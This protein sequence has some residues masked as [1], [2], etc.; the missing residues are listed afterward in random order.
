MVNDNY[1]FDTQTE[2]PVEKYTYIVNS[3]FQIDGSRD[4]GKKVEEI[5]QKKTIRTFASENG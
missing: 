5:I 4:V 2:I 1:R 3:Y